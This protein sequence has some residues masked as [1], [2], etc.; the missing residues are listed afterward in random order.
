MFQFLNFSYLNLQGLIFFFQFFSPPA[1]P[2]GK[3]TTW[4]V[5][6]SCWLR[7]GYDSRWRPVFIFFPY[8]A[9]H[10]YKYLT[11]S[12]TRSVPGTEAFIVP[13]EWVAKSK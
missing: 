1:G 3:W 2:G 7:L 4:Y 11:G 12:Q 10:F 9:K 13:K 5:V 6:H 8:S